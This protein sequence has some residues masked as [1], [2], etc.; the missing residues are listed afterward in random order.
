MPRLDEV[1]R[2]R[3]ANIGKIPKPTVL[4]ASFSPEVGM[5]VL[6][7]NTR[8]TLEDLHDLTIT[9]LC[10]STHRAIVDLAVNC[11][12]MTIV[13]KT[14]GRERDRLT[15]PGLLGVKREKELPSNLRLAHGGSPLQLLSEAS[16]ICGLHSTLLLEALAA[17]RPVVVPRYAEATDPKIAWYLFD[18]GAAAITVASPEE[19]KARLRTLALARTPVP[20]D[21]PPST[22]K[23]LSQWVG[24]HDGKAGARAAAAIIRTIRAAHA[25][26]KVLA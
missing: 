16:V 10:V 15:L 23:L 11:P 12:E 24:N 4:F 21:L 20:A 9:E 22:S 14:K 18:L 6:K 25:Q 1:H 7:T 8:E 2:W 13:V 17:G 3:K 19:L 5:P 26:E